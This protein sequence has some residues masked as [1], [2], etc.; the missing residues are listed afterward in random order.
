VLDAALLGATM[1]ELGGERSALT[2]ALLGGA[3]NP[4]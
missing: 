1:D 4:A 2:R 3:G